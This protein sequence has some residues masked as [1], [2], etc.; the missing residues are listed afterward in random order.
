[1]KKL[2]LLLLFAIAATGF[3][4]FAQTSDCEEK[5]EQIGVLKRDTAQLG[6]KLRDIEQQV[7]KLQPEYTVLD[8]KVKGMDKELAQLKSDTVRLAKR[9]KELEKQAVKPE[10]LKKQVKTLEDEQKNLKK[11]LAGLKNIKSQFDEMSRAKTKSDSVAAVARN[12]QTFLQTRL[13]EANTALSVSRDSLRTSLAGSGSAQ[14]ELS[15]CNDAKTALSDQ[16]ALLTDRVKSLETDIAAGQ[17]EA[18][19]SENLKNTLIANAAAD[20]KAIIAKPYDEL[21]RD[22]LALLI[23]QYAVL[24]NIQPD[25]VKYSADVE[26]LN[27]DIAAIAEAESLL[28]KALDRNAVAAASGRLGTIT[29]SPNANVNAKAITVKAK[30]DGYGTNWTAFNAMLTAIK[31]IDNDVVYQTKDVEAIDKAHLEEILKIT[32]KYQDAFAGYRF[33]ETKLKEVEDIKRDIKRDTTDSGN[34]VHKDV[35]GIL[36]N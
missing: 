31:R 26:Q 15:S 29:Q 1:M 10:T 24:S 33:L 36:N 34:N 4:S 8:G 27:R 6:K 12:S 25:F 30:L 28:R 16:N 20:Y 32:G 3:Q 11:E 35:S 21:N 14:N 7:N 23:K 5:I 13:N 22:V 19:K 18:G 9:V 17:T 2:L